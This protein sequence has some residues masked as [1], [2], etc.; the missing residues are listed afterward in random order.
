MGQYAMFNMKKKLT[1]KSK[2]T[3]QTILT[4]KSTIEGIVDRGTVDVIVRDQVLAQLASGKKLRI[5]LGIDPSGPDLHLGHAVPLRKMKQFQQAGH[6]AV[7]VIGDWTARIGDPTGK[8]EMRPQLS[9]SQVKQNADKYLKQL[10]LILDKTKTEI[11]WQSSWFNKFRLQE[12]INLLGKFTVAQLTDRDDFRERQKIGKEIGY[13][14]PV[15]SLLQGYD[16]VAV[17]A[18]IEIGATEQLFNILK[19]RDVQVLFGQPAQGVITNKILIGLDGTM[20]MG[21]STKNYIGLLESADDMY[22]KIM[23]IP[24]QLILQYF[25]LCSDL[26]EDELREI[27]NQIVSRSI[28]PRDAKMRLAKNIVSLYHSTAAAVKAEKNFVSIFQKREIPTDVKIVKID[29]PNIPLLE[30]L[31]GIGLVNSN[32]EGQRILKEGGIK[33]EGRVIKDAKYNV[34]PTPMGIMISRGK[35][36]W[37]KII[38]A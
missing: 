27:K 25:E 5:K 18:D 37:C 8:N 34:Q 23:S 2:K 33:I 21:K 35:R 36:Q 16:S 13:H 4:D 31:L 38:L 22:G 17:E 19:G 20:K 12:V 6:Q 24:D 26:P 11:V 10:F 32:S 30:L 28:N 15:Y 1:T 3:T 29:K 14:E 7:I 9:A